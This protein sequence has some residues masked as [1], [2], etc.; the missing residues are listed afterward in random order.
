M[1]L[2]GTGYPGCYQQINAGDADPGSRRCYD[3]IMDGRWRYPFDDVLRH[4]GYRS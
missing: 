1:E 4:Q 3:R 2:P